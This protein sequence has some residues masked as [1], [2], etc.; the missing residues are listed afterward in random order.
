MGRLYIII[1]LICLFGINAGAQN[2]TIEDSISN[3]KEQKEQTELIGLDCFSFSYYY[4]ENVF[5]RNYDFELHNKQRNLRMWSNEI[6]VLGYATMMVSMGFGSWLAIARD[7]SLW[8]VIPVETIISV[9]I[10]LGSD[11]WAKQIW[12]KADAIQ[13]LSV[14]IIE[15]NPRPDLCIKDYSLKGNSNLGLGIGFQYKF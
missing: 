2:P 8:L 14:S 11:I 3:K 12:R 1:V 6:R 13:E 10:G 5:E 4:S 15:I 9:G 7:W